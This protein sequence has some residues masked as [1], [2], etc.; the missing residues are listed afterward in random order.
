MMTLFNIL[1]P[2][3]LD[4]GILWAMVLCMFVSFC[5]ISSAY[6]YWG[7]E[8]CEVETVDAKK[9]AKKE[10]SQ[11]EIAKIQ[12]LKQA[13]YEY[14]LARKAL[15]DKQAEDSDLS[16]YEYP[17]ASKLE[18]DF[19]NDNEGS[20]SQTGALSGLGYA[21]Y[22]YP[23]GVTKIVEHAYKPYI[24][25]YQAAMLRLTTQTASQ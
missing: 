12:K 14:C 3:K 6:S 1:R 11:E 23:K 8:D 21:A 13:E 22:I 24:F 10:Y 2:I 18:A 9:L 7:E 4:K 25:S 17:Y 16:W 15:A 5:N 20:R 19:I